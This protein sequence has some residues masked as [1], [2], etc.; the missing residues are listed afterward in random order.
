M[1]TTTSP[2]VGTRIA[3]RLAKTVGPRRYAMWFD[4]S[5]RFDYVDEQSTLCVTVPNRFIADWIDRNF[6]SDLHA[7]AHEELGQRVELDVQVA[8]DR[9]NDQRTPHEK[10]EV[11]DAPRD[12]VDAMP[13]SRKPP[14]SRRKPHPHAPRLRRKLDEF[15]VGPS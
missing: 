3:S 2:N 14:A 1:T 13:A 7:A 9:F 11:Q 10:P 12:A 5:A 4:R 15:I 8:P 6:H